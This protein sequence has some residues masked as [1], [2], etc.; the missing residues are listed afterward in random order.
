MEGTIDQDNVDIRDRWNVR[1]HTGLYGRQHTLLDARDVNVWHRVAEDARLEPKTLSSFAR[2]Y[3][4][5][6]P[7]EFPF[8][9]DVL[10]VS[11]VNLNGV[12]DRHT[13]NDLQRAN[14]HVSVEALYEIEREAEFRFTCTSD[15]RATS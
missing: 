4:Q 14:L 5:R 15:D 1:R 13:M 7:G 3:D 9:T 8:G 6:D 11:L 10:L 2:R 12:R